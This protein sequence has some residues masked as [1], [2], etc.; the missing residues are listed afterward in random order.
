MDTSLYGKCECG[1]SVRAMHQTRTATGYSVAWRHFVIF[2]QNIVIPLSRCFLIL[3]AIINEQPDSMASLDLT[4]RLPAELMGEIF[5]ILVESR[6]SYKLFSANSDAA[7]VPWSLSRVCSR[8]RQLALSM[9]SLWN[10]INVTGAYDYGPKV[11]ALKK[12]PVGLL[13]L[14]LRRSGAVP[15]SL[16]YEENPHGGA[17][18]HID[19]VGLQLF[20]TILVHAGRWRSVHFTVTPA[21]LTMLRAGCFQQ[22]KTLTVILLPCRNIV[23]APASLDI[24]AGMPKLETLEIEGSTL[25]TAFILPDIPTPLPSLKKIHLTADLDTEVPYID[26]NLYRFF[27]LS[28]IRSIRYLG[29]EDSD[30]LVDRLPIAVTSNVERIETSCTVLI[31]NLV[32]PGLRHLWLGDPNDEDVPLTRVTDTVPP[33]IHRSDCE[34]VSFHLRS[35]NF[36]VD[37]NIPSVLKAMPTLEEFRLFSDLTFMRWTEKHREAVMAVIHAMAETQASGFHILPR[38]KSF[39]LGAGNQYSGGELGFMGDAFYSMLSVRSHGCLANV[40]VRVSDRRSP[41]SFTDEQRKTLER[42]AED[43]AYAHLLVSLLHTRSA[44]PPEHLPDKYFEYK[45]D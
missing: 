42:L 3:T 32:T 17:P 8:W 26:A 23:T 39:S 7:D 22:L 34:L 37:E 9:P 11:A 6:G 44:V 1:L 4:A 31:E 30:E 10:D 27:T 33:L 15:L 24:F 28:S 12:N 5:Q 43:K 36:E 40:C 16:Y 29:N 25:P 41:I 35:I 14:V 13:E 19:A 18:D 21:L 38:L 20:H 45:R 2:D